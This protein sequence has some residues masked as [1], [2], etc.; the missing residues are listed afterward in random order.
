MEEF[1]RKYGYKFVCHALNHPN[2]KAG[3]E[4]GFYTVETNFLPGRS[5]ESMEELNRSAFEW[6]T[7]R[8]FHRPTGKAG[9]IPA[10]AFEYE[11]AFL[12]K[13]PPYVEPPYQDHHRVIDQYGYVAFAGNYYWVPEKSRQTVTLLEYGDCLKLY[14]GRQFLLNYRLP[15]EGVRNA[16]FAPDGFPKPKYRPKNRK[17][18]TKREEDILRALSPEM[19]RYLTQFLSAKGVS[20]H[21]FIREIY[22]L[23]LKLAPTL[24][25]QTVQRAA[26]YRVTDVVA[27]ERIANLLMKRSNYTI[28]EVDVDDEFRDRPAYLEGRSSDKADLS[29]FDR[30]LEENCNE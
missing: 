10:K 3:N 9:L 18:P 21:R 11:K 28:P 7:D 1:S 5:F 27:I 13:L 15:D 12:S 26:Y 24:F 6:A 16:I 30:F 14:S 2:R 23:K 29:N 19:D 25:F 4:R 17:Q 22:R 20:K 8:S